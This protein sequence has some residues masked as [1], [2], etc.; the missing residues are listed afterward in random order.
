MSSV[1]IEEIALGVSDVKLAPLIATVVTTHTVNEFGDNLVV[2][3][4]DGKTRLERIRPDTGDNLEQVAR[5]TKTVFKGWGDTPPDG[6][7][8]GDDRYLSNPEEFKDHDKSKCY[9]YKFDSTDAA[10]GILWMTLYARLAYPNVDCNGRLIDGGLVLFVRSED[11]LFLSFDRV[12]AREFDSTHFG[13]SR[14]NE[15]TP[16]DTAVRIAK[17]ATGSDVLETA[18]GGDFAVISNHT[19]TQTY[20]NLEW[21]FHATGYTL[22]TPPVVDIPLRRD[23]LV[24]ERADGDVKRG[25]W[26][27]ADVTGWNFDQSFLSHLSMHHKA[28]AAVALCLV[29]PVPNYLD[30]FTIDVE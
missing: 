16:L 18:H 9:L 3:D 12:Q 5:H 17:D 22:L 11:R 6:F 21:T 25:E 27:L 23:T 28:A 13:H 29:A 2:R 26:A 15:A 7:V 10:H 4:P 14:H 20:S 19:Y 8:E 24:R 1:E 30:S